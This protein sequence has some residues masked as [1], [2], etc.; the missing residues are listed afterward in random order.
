VRRRV[1]VGAGVAAPVLAVGLF[2][3]LR[4]PAPADRP[5]AAG[6]AVLVTPAPVTPKNHP[7]FGEYVPPRPAAKP[8]PA[9]APKPRATPSRRASQP[10][11]ARQPCPSGWADI[12]MLRRWCQRHGYSLR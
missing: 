9:P 4:D 1:L 8:P 11:K 2:V 12:P 10:P 5:D 7:T 3:G 6:A